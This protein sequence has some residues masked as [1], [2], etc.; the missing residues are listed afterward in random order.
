MGATI[1]KPG[2]YPDVTDEEYHA[3]PVVGGSLSS[4]GARR[5]L[6]P[7]CPAKFRWLA[8]HPE[9][10]RSATLD[11]GRAAH[12]WVLG[13]GPELV[14]LEHDDLRTKAA[15]T[16]AA[17]AEAR[18]AIALKPAEYDEIVEMAAVIE[19]HPI[20]GKLFARDSGKPEQTIVWQDH[21]TG[22]MRRLRLD[23]LPN[24]LSSAGRLL[25]PDYK[26]VRSAEPSEIEKSINNY[27]YHMQGDWYIDGVLSM[28]LADTVAFLLVCQE[29]TAPYV[30]TVVQIHPD[31]LLAGHVLNEYAIETYLKC[32]NSGHWPGY[33]ENVVLGR[34]PGYAEIQFER[35][36]ERGDYNVKAKVKEIVR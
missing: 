27:G 9:K 6:P 21:R 20:A 12:R 15:R 25:L 1:T 35:A 26:T 31:T 4:T 22:T 36:R 8:D 2:L 13:A 17:E 24:T 14:R 32:V 7:S 10:G 23:W 18:G 30:V 33:A 29:K 16:E 5:L 3:D 34:L 28:G 11:F 19:A